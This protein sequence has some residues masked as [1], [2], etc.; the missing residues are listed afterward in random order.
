VMASIIKRIIFL[1][2]TILI[3]ATS[4]FIASAQTTT[5]SVTMSGT[6]SKFVELKSNGAVTLT[7][8]SGGGVT[9]DGTAN[10][11]LAVTINLGELGPSNSASFVKA[12]VPIKLRSNAS[13]ALA[14]SATAAAGNTSD[15]ALGDVGFGITS[16]TR[17]GT[18]VRSGAGVNDTNAT[19]GDPTTAAGGE[20]STSGRYEFTG[21][22]G[23][24]ADF[25]SSTTALSGDRILNAVPVS[26]TNGLTANA[27][28][29]IKP[30]FYQEGSFSV[31]VSFTATTP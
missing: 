23:D 21:T 26:N 3:V 31:T 9:A 7:G 19:P 13:Y 27:V 2:L 1:P 6:V 12:V 14:V 20:N 28:F 5:G 4:A 29:A 24:L 22:R 10:N 18:G 16:I 15:I 30:Q 11:P 17:S 25:S 8:N